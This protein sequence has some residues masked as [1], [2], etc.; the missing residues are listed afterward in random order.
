[1]TWGLILTAAEPPPHPSPTDP[2][3]LGLLTPQ[4]RRA[5]QAP[6]CTAGDSQ[7]APA[8][9][10]AGAR[11]QPDKDG[12]LFCVKKSI[13]PSDVPAIGGEVPRHQLAGGAGAELGAA[14]P[15]GRPPAHF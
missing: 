8:P 10:L 6:P 2:L 14:A 7:E 11:V 4:W 5:R 13:I 9:P 12:L 3:P 15:G 1:M